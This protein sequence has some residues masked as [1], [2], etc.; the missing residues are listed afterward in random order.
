MVM[1]TDPNISDLLH[2]P[3]G[4]QNTLL[5]TTVRAPPAAVGSYNA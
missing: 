3:F 5:R 1:T 4:L 2:E